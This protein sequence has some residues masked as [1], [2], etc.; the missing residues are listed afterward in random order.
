[1]G[2]FSRLAN[3][4][5]GREPVVAQTASKR[6]LSGAKVGQ[7]PIWMQFQRIGGSLT[8]QMVSAIIVQADSGDQ[9]RL[10]DLANESRQ[11]DCTLHSVLQ[12]RELALNGLEWQVEPADKSRRKSRKVAEFCEESLRNCPTFGRSLQDLQSAVYYGHSVDE[13]MWGRDGR[14]TVPVE[15]THIQPRRFEFRQSDGRLCL[16]PRNGLGDVSV[17]L[18]VDQ[19][20]GKFVQHQP[21]INGDVPAREGLSRVLMWAALY[22]NWD[23]KSWLQLGE[24]GWQPTRLGYYKKGADNEDIAALAEVLQ[25]LTAAGWASLPDTTE[26]K[27]EWPKNAIAGSTHREFADFLAGEMAKAVLGQTLTT[28]AGD[29]GA[30]SLGDVH[31]R[32]RR[33][34][35]EADA[36]SIEYTEDRFV[37]APMVLMNFGRSETPPRFKFI[38]AETA[39]V[40]SFCNAMAKFAPIARI[41]AGWARV[42][43]GAPEPTDDEEL[44]GAWSDI[45]IDPKTGLPSEPDSATE[46]PEPPADPNVPV[47]PP[48]E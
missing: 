13:T 23:I 43:I 30:R 33:D 45:P 24:A 34:V 41:P 35:L 16:L 37:I 6:E 20:F 46:T 27:I 12:T 5:T 7:E 10:V 14:F 18:I 32:V 25:H 44:L 2:L 17:D 31:D 39:N 4:F 36:K 3:A 22:R 26:L 21:R 15:F 1:M 38:T 42:Q 9:S 8:P 29:K 40:E 11:K 28:E 48:A 47:E 19:P